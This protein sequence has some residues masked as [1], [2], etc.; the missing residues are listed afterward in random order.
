M[1]IKR[2]TLYLPYYASFISVERTLAELV[3][4]SFS[5]GTNSVNTP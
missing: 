4:V 1:N 2:G 5:K 3:W